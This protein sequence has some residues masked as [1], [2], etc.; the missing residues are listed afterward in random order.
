MV[1]TLALVYL[2]LTLIAAC[3]LGLLSVVYNRVFHIPAGQHGKALALLWILA[4][5]SVLFA[6]PLSLFQGILFG[7]Q[8]I[9]LLNSVQILTTVLYGVM[10]WVGLAHGAG[11]VTLAWLN[12]TAMLAEYTLYLG[13]A[14][15]C[16]SGLRISFRLADRKLLRSVASFSMAQFIVSMAALVRLRTDPLIVQWF[17]PLSQVA[18]YAVA[19]RIAESAL[20]LTKQGINVLAPLMAQLHGAGETDK[21]RTALLGAGKMAFFGSVILTAPICL[22]AREI[23]VFWVGPAFAP[24]A[25]TLI[26]L[27]ISMCLIAP[28]LVASNVL[29]M[30]GHHRVTARAEVVGMLLNLAVSVALA[31]PLGLVGVAIGTLTST[32][33]IDLLYIVA[34]ACRVNQI[35][36]GT[37]VRRVMLA[38][39]VPGAAQ[40]AT[41]LAL[42]T[43]LPPA[44]LAALLL[45]SVPGAVAAFALFW[46]AFVEP[47]EKTRLNGIGQRTRRVAVVPPL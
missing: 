15:R 43:V 37:F 1:S 44:N 6:L 9:A 22:F 38:G 41:T 10:A 18:V 29:A 26:V 36:Y 13:F 23:V 20:L 45:E 31:R 3:G 17:L 24:A 47:A 11:V 39:L 12:L 33:L 42:K 5:R 25:P 16:V 32:I 46:L 8:R 27:M 35:T 14:F 19:L 28:Q 2:L 30:T 40:V 7:E 4:A 34:A 21:I